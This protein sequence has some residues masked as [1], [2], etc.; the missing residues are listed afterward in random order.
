MK[1]ILQG[2]RIHV[3]EFSKLA[4]VQANVAVI[5]KNDTEL[6]MKCE[7]NLAVAAKQMFVM[8]GVQNVKEVCYF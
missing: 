7:G 6:G 4:T 2:W 1:I 5:Q 3:K 8:L